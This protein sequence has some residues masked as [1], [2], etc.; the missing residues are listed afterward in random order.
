MINETDQHILKK[1]FGCK[2]G[3]QV[4]EPQVLITSRGSNLFFSAEKFRNI[5]IIEYEGMPGMS[6]GA[7]VK[8]KKVI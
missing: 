4:E 1:V 6:D 5:G 3:K 7:I 8:Y 2:K